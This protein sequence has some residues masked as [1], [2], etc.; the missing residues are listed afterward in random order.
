MTGCGAAHIGD[1]SLV[2]HARPGIE[3]TKLGNDSI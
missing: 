3:S 2:Q 1:W